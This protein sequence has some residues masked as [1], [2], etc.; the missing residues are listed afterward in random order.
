MLQVDSTPQAIFFISEG[1]LD[2]VSSLLKS[3][4]SSE[5]TTEGTLDVKDAPFLS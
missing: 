5:S 3:N 4:T 2:V 1:R